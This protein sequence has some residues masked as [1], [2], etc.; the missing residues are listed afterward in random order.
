MTERTQAQQI[1]VA[2]EFDTG[3]PTAAAAAAARE[4]ATFARAVTAYRFWYPTIS[5]AAMFRGNRAI[6]IHANETMGIAS[7]G[8]RQ[9]GFTANSD[10]RS[11]PTST[12]LS[13]RCGR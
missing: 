10:T 8:P 9:I 12:R 11:G 1:G 13:T 6:G 5:V 2:Y 7:T 3:Y 4:E